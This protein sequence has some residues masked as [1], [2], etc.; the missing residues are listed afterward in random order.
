MN[1][2]KSTI[3]VSR[4]TTFPITSDDSEGTIYGTPIPVPGT[5]K[6]A[7]TDKGS[8]NVFDADDGAYETDSYIEDMGHEITNADIPPE[9]ENVWRGLGS[10]KYMVEVDKDAAGKAPDFG[11]AW[12]LRKHD[13]HFRLARYYKGKF[14]FASNVG[15]ETK[16]SNGAPNHQTAVAT[17]KAVYRDSDDKAYAFIDTA[18]LPEGVTESEAIEKWF[19]DPNWYP[20]DATATPTVQEGE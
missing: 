17:F 13:G 5:V 1:K 18:V 8:T 4:Y 6:I 11:V 12:M 15:G 19:T 14:G 2:P 3:G 9:V 16:P 20:T 7:P 10:N